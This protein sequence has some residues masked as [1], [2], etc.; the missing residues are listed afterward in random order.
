MF[1]GT[2]SLGTAYTLKKFGMG[3][4][5]SFPQLQAGDFVNLNRA[6]GSGHAVVFLG[7]LNRGESQPSAAHTDQTQ[8]F[9]YFSA[10]GEGRRDGGFG[11]RNAYFVG[12]CPVPRGR[13]DDCNVLRKYVVKADGSVTQSQ[14]FLNTGE[15]FAPGAWKV[16][17]ALAAIEARITRGFEEEQGL[18]RGNGLEEAVRAELERELFPAEDQYAD[19]SGEAP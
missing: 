1:A 19:H 16:E 2:G 5:K 10:Q 14:N 18:T 4:Q 9:R 15:M 13:D 7:F 3:Q 6:S 8:G 12:A 11:Y 17:E